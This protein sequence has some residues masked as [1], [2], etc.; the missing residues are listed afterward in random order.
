MFNVN[1]EF[2]AAKV[3]GATGASKIIYFNLHGTFRE[4]RDREARPEPAGERRPEPLGTLPDA[5]PP[6]GVRARGPGR[7]ISRREAVLR[8]PG[9]TEA[10]IKVGHSVVALERGAKRARILAPENGALV[11]E[12]YAR[13]GCGT[14]TSRDVYEGIRRGDV[15]DAS[16]IYDLIE[17]PVRSGTLVERP[18]GAAG[19][20]HRIAFRVHERRSDRGHRAAAEVRGGVRRNR[21]P[22][23]LAPEPTG[24]LQPKE[25]EQ[26]IH[27]G[28]LQGPGPRRGRVVVVE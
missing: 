6:R 11:R 12:L 15:D 25:E 16:G 5:R 21:L 24:C 2:L 22:G 9:S 23:E 27:E 26:D 8:A 13:D 7:R 18:N 14:L 19:K 28:D 4:P 10:L 17:P 3:A 20:G 1:S